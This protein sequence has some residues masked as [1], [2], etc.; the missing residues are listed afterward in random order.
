MRHPYTKKIFT[1]LGFPSGSIIMNLPTVEELQETGVQSLGWEDPLEEELATHFSIL[2][3]EIPCTE[4]PGVHGV[5]KS[6]M[7]LS[8]RAFI[9]YLN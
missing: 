8:T 3:W 9:V 6:Q 1:V 5:A 7:R 4:K 2:T